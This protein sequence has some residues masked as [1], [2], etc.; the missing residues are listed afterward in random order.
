MHVIVGLA[1]TVA[2]G[3]ISAYLST[4]IRA[5][6]SGWWG[7]ATAVF[8]MLGWTYLT[9]FSKVPLPLQTLTFEVV[10]VTA[11]LVALFFYGFRPTWVQGAGI[12][13]AVSG[14]AML[15]KG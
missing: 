1:L 11:T 14:L 5:G 7:P 6:W 12:L 15:A 2:G 9:R 8:P 4:R 3:F 13:V 10:L